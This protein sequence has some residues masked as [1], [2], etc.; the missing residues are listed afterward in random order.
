MF[1]KSWKNFSL[2]YGF[3]WLP[4]TTHKMHSVLLR[5]FTT[6]T[7]LPPASRLPCCRTCTPIHFHQLRLF[8]HTVQKDWEKGEPGGL[9]PQIKSLSH[10]AMAEVGACAGILGPYLYP[11]RRMRILV[12]ILHLILHSISRK[13]GGSFGCRHSPPPCSFS[14]RTFKLIWHCLPNCTPSSY[15]IVPVTENMSS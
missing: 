13:R 1:P 15:I 9:Q 10:S 14:T 2:G 7:T 12:H 5:F 3:K 4:H 8:T 6:T 11:H